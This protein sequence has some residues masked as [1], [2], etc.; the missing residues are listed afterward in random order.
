[1]SPPA[2]NARSPAPVITMQPIASST[3][4]RF[5]APLPQGL[6]AL[7]PELHGLWTYEFRFGRVTQAMVDLGYKG[8]VLWCTAH[9]RYGR[10]LRLA[11]VQHPAPPLV[12][13]AQW[14]A[15]A[16]AN[17]PPVLVASA[18]YAT[19]VRDGQIV[20]DGLP[21]TTVAFVLY[22]QVPQADG[23]T[24]RNI[25]LG[26]AVAMPVPGT[27]GATAVAQLPQADQAWTWHSFAANS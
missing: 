21:R 17:L 10:P 20:G 25:Q 6:A 8:P 13:A 16:A 15:P 27:P 2:E 23:S 11:G 22:A 19:P 5:T 26:H 4:I 18:A 7:A 24:F 1:M 9:G 14:Q 3:S 12:A